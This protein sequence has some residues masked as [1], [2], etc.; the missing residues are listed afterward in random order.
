[1]CLYCGYKQF[2]IYNT[3]IKRKKKSKKTEKKMLQ[4]FCL[5]CNNLT[6]I[7]I[8]NNLNPPIPPPQKK[9]EKNQAKLCLIKNKKKKKSNQNLNKTKTP[10]LAAFLTK[11]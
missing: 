1:M 6:E 8:Q 10:G 5:A 2:G 4:Q 9:I 3:K 11:F 7:Q